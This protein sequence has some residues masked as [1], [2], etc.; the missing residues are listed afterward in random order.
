M[1]D[2]TSSV[3]N[4]NSTST[5][6][7][8]RARLSANFDTFLLMLTTQLRNQDPTQPMDANQ[9]TQ[10]LVQ[11]SQIEQQLATNDRLDKLISSAQSSQATTALGYLGTNITYD[12]SQQT[13]GTS[14]TRWS[15]TPQQSGEYMVR[16]R[17]ASGKVVKEQQ[18]TLTAGQATDYSWDNLRSDGSPV[19]TGTYTLE[20]WRGSGANATKVDVVNSGKVTQVDASGSEIIVMIGTQKVPVSKVKTITL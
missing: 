10:Q 2:Q 5:S 20:L 3:M 14:E 19:G 4:N 11:Y 12:A 1:V 7:S 16:I 8:S 6:S 18:M 17:D 15:F 13:P 9:F